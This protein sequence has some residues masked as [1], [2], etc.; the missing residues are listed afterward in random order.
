VPSDSD[1][2]ELLIAASER[3]REPRRD[4]IAGVMGP[5]APPELCNGRSLPIVAAEIIETFD[6]EL[7]V[8]ALT[9]P[10]GKEEEFDNAVGDMLEALLTRFN[11]GAT[12]E[13]RAINFLA[14]RSSSLYQ[15]AGLQAVAGNVMSFAYVRRAPVGGT[16]R[17]I[18]QI[19]F[20]ITRRDTGAFV[21]RRA[22]NVDTSGFMMMQIPPSR[23]EFGDRLEVIFG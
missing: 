8:S 5:I 16:G 15:E 14:T 13:D 1:D 12:D 7:I 22:A 4:V 23:P 18:L 20:E 11:T 21:E 3:L 17:N 19:V 2:F 9:V 6:P 10:A